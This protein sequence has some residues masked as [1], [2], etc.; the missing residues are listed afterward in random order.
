MF[1]YQDAVAAE[2]MGITEV[3][4]RKHRSRGMAELNVL[5]PPSTDRS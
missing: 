1:G 5:S 4:L 2:V 3:N